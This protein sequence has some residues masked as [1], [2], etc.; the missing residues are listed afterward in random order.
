M[1]CLQR[2]GARGFDPFQFILHVFYS[3]YQTLF[4]FFFIDFL[5][6]GFTVLGT[7]IFQQNT[8]RLQGYFPPDQKKA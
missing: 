6:R 8:G 2:Q 3:A 5:N 1:D 4:I 7:M